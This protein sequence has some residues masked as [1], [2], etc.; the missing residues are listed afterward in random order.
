MI[1]R[2][3][4]V[5]PIDTLNLPKDF[6]ER[7]K[8]SFGKFTEMTAEDY[9]DEDRLL[10]LDN[11]RLHYIRRFEAEEEVKCTII[12]RT[13]YELTENGDFPDKEDFWSFGFM[14]ECYELGQSSGK[15]RNQYYEKNHRDNDKTMKVIAAIVK[16]VMNWKS[17]G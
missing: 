7:V 17:E 16:I 15:F 8:Y 10:Y 3:P 1:I 13:E 12:D 11:L 14:A 9:T 4:H 6:N 2:L 5:E